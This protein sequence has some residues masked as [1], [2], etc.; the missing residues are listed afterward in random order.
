M[1]F[2]NVAVAVRPALS[3]PALC[4]TAFVSRSAPA[5]AP[6]PRA[7]VTMLDN[8]QPM[9]TKAMADYKDEYG[10]FAKRGWGATSKAEVWNGRHAMFGWL[11]IIGTAE[12]R[13]HGLMPDGNLDLAQWGVIGSLGDGTAISNERAAIIVAHIH[14]LFVSIAAALAP[15]SFQDKLLLEDGEADA[16]PAGLFPN[17][18]PGLNRQAELW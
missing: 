6:A 17:F 14:F 11:M 9:F 18:V 5:A 4:R 3:R 1:A 8:I 2:V 16:A 7:A 15:F 12:A 10:P 13:N